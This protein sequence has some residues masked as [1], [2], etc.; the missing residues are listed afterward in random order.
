[1]LIQQLTYPR[2]A[3]FQQIETRAEQLLV[4]PLSKHGDLAKA[5]TTIGY[6]R[7]VQNRLND[8]RIE[9]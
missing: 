2:T 5:H 9:L 3:I 8:S 4:E 6:L 1:V 7:R